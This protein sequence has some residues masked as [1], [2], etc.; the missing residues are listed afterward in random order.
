MKDI[1]KNQKEE[2]QSEI[3]K[4]GSDKITEE[5]ENSEA[6]NVDSDKKLISGDETQKSVEK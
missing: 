2:R 1:E 5:E 4:N 6:Q 3:N